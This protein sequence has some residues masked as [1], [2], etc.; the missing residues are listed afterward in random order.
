MLIVKVCQMNVLKNEM[1]AFGGKAQMNWFK[2]TN[3]GPYLWHSVLNNRWGVQQAMFE[4][5]CDNIGSLGVT[6]VLHNSD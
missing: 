6:Y 1:F 5:N 2:R 3:N 4:K